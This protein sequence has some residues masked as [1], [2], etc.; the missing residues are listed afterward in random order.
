MAT[1]IFN[2]D[3]SLRTTVADGSLDKSTS[4]QF[5]GRG[6]LNYGEP[7][8]QNVLWVMQNFANPTAPLNPVVG[9][10]WFNT[11]GNQFKIWNGSEWM[12]TNTGILTGTTPP[13]SSGLSAGDLWFDTGKG[14]LH[15]WSGA[16]WLLVGP[17]GSS[18]PLTDPVITSTSVLPTNTTI[19]SVQ[20]SDGVNNHNVIRFII[21]GFLAAILSPSDVAF[22]P[23]PT[24]TG[25]SYINP[26][27]NLNS[28]IATNYAPINS[29]AFTGSPTAPTVAYPSA[30][31]T[32]LATTG[33]V[34]TNF[35]PINSPSLTGVPKSITPAATDN[36]TQIATTAFVVTNVATSTN[37]LNAWV[38]SNYVSTSSLV[39]GG[40]A[41]T[42]YVNST[43]A[44][45]ISP[46]LTGA[47]QSPTAQP[48]TN[49]TMISTTQFVTTNFAA[50]NGSASQ[51]F[52]ASLLQVNA[53]GSSA[54]IYTYDANDLVFRTGG[55]GAY[56]YTI[57]DPNGNFIAPGNV[58]AY[59]DLRLK[60]KFKPLE[61]ATEIL[62]SLNNAVSRYT[63]I[64][65][66]NKEHVG[67]LAQ[68][69]QES[70]PEAVYETG[71]NVNGVENV[72]SLD[73][74]PI[75]AVLVSALN[76]AM[77]RIEALEAKIAS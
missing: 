46:T 13:G 47:P 39:N 55:P 54:L 48:G 59:S 61:N 77:N 5:P 33:F 52:N 57:I 37:Q 66:D 23:Q 10:A 76:Q 19:D 63:R 4:L 70:L 67:F 53:S 62:R 14:Q 44:P 2:Y 29:P 15:V 41:T 22:A 24:I 6:Y 28:T 12:S 42:A 35:A 56:V 64:G 68:L 71:S 51:T 32:A 74:R 65:A 3:G 9:Q 25:F 1:N 73:D 26:G 20:I 34:S 36:S 7:I 16:S 11:V 50:L 40:F 72:L 45:L 60:T 21:A 17:I 75:I 18:D 8:N 43:F 30:I 27:L 58:T 38:Q 31:T 69:V 49:N